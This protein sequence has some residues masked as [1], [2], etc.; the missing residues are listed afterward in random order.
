MAGILQPYA[1]SLSYNLVQAGGWAGVNIGITRPTQGLEYV[2]YRSGDVYRK[3]IL[4]DGIL[5]GAILVGQVE[6]AGLLYS[7]VRKKIDVSKWTRQL[8]DPDLNYGKLFALFKR[9]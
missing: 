4:R 8:L 9:M 2:I 3:L 1:G 5:V 7:L 6:N